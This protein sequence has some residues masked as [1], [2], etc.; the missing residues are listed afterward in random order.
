LPNRVRQDA[1]WGIAA[2]ALSAGIFAATKALAADPLNS[3]NRPT[4]ANASNEFEAHNEFNLVPVAG[5]TTDIGIGGGYFMGFDRISPGKAPYLWNIESAGFVTFAPR[6][7]GGVIVPYQDD[8]VKLT[9]PRFILSTIELEIRPE[10][11]WETTLQYDGLGDASSALLPTGAPNKY[12]EYGRLHPELDVDLRWRVFDHLIGRTGVR[13]I[14]NWVQVA[15]DSSLS[16]DM[17]TG[18]A[19]VKKLLGSTAASGVALFN[20]GVQFDNR[21]NTVSTHRGTFDSFDARVSPGGTTWM[22]YR[23]AQAT[24]DVRFYIP[25]WMPRITLAGRVAGDVLYGAPPFYELARFEDTYAIG[26]LNG[27]RGV[28]AQ[29][30]YGK[31]KALGNVELRT[32]LVSFHALGKPLIFGIVG[33]LD[34]GRVWAD[35]RPQ[36]ELDGHGIGLK[37]GAGGGLRLQSGSAFVIRVDVAWSPDATPVGG[38]FAAGQMF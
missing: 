38:Y 28:P 15:S 5:G 1:R 33:F 30:Y 10:Y 11:S 22:P 35:T 12:F 29:R 21:D 16:R 4:G 24:A 3:S 25:L 6:K 13:Y 31:V 36:P 14:Q 17:L 18:S 37:Y 19:E 26:G 8:Y 34:G 32:E 2:V 23:Y 27:V 7:G 20:Y 9:I